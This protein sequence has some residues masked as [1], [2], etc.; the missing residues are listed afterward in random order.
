MMEILRMAPDLKIVA[1]ALEPLSEQD[2]FELA[3]H[4]LQK[5]G[6]SET[7]QKLLEPVSGNAALA[8]ITHDLTMLYDKLVMH[9]AES[10]VITAS[11][12]EAA[13][14]VYEEYQA[15]CQRAKDDEMNKEIA[16]NN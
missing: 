12:V 1:A 4:L 11:S 15:A 2:H 13:H 14:K 3:L 5:L 10:L 16:R 7:I 9:H 6:K 8:K